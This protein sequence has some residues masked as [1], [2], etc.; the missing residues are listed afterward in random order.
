MDATY[1]EPMVE[2]PV[3]ENRFSW[4]RVWMLF[5]LYYPQL[6]KQIIF[7][8]ILSALAIF[9]TAWLVEV[10]D[11]T[12]VWDER[13]SVAWPMLMISIMYYLAP[14]GFARRDVRQL[15]A[16]LPVTAAEKL[17]FIL[18][19]LF[20]GVNLLTSGVSYLAAF[21]IMPIC[22]QMWDMVLESFQLFNTTFGFSVWSV[23]GFSMAWLF[24][25]IVMYVV[26][27]AKRNRVLKGIIAYF[28]ATIAV[29]ILSGLAGMIGAMYMIMKHGQDYAQNLIPEADP[30]QITAEMT[31]M[32][33]TIMYPVGAVAVVVLIWLIWK[34]YK[35]L[36]YSGI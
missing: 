24:Q 7:F 12:S 8:P 4:R 26:L 27:I 33:Q 31:Q 36:K 13:M 28:G 32:V 11:V 15:C 6:K 35:K 17:V 19:Y 14:I 30:D 18:I 21:V 34:M 10:N 16:M 1:I 2:S 5:Q 29:G 22:P 20:I 23:S 3:Q 25:I 9:L